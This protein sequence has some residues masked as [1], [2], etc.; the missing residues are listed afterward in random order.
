MKNIC[1]FTIL[2]LLL[3]MP[4]SVWGQQEKQDSS[5]RLREWDEIQRDLS[6]EKRKIEKITS[7]EKSVLTQLSSIDRQLQESRSDLSRLRQHKSVIDCALKKR[8]R[9]LPNSRNRRRF[10]AA[11]YN[12]ALPRLTGITI[13]AY[14]RFYF[15][16]RHSPDLWR[17]WIIFAR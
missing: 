5:E 1:I 8:T 14:T 17:T 12:G 16:R 4:L 11:I 3:L 2:S 7:E 13:R 9:A 6:E 15:Q 10:S